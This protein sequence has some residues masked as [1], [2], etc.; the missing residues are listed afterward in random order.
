MMAI[1]TV[2]LQEQSIS[3][4]RELGSYEAL[5]SRTGASFK[6]IAD[7]FRERPDALPS[8]FVSREIA[9]KFARDATEILRDANITD[10]GIRIHGAW[11]YPAQLREAE[12]PIALFYY[13]GWWDLASSPSVAVVGTR[14]PS[15]EA[16]SRTR[17]MVQAL[18][19]DGYTVVS[20]LAQ[21]VDTVAHETAIQE[22]GL[23]IGVIGTPLSV[24]YPAT[25]KALQ[26]TI[27]TRYLLISQVPIVRASHQG[28]KNNR[29][30]FPERNITMSALTKATII[31]EAGETSGTLTQARAAI[32]QG[33]LLFI[34]DSCFQN[35]AL[36]WPRRFEEAGAIRVRT[37]DEI[38]ER[39][40]SPAKQG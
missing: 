27:A 28:P 3:P 12:H 13:R 23:T 32:K 30:F 25:N 16:I 39:L 9:D 38:K 18:V 29:M 40:G 31:I 8:D 24:S 14:S 35:P 36:S 37:Y 19:K 17:K 4:W 11:E 34:L 20:G 26:E 22:G 21:G 5:W 10:F 6:Q 2:P 7:L 1:S 15:V 33:R